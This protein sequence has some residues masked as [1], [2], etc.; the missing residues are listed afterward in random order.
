MALH[1]FDDI[2]DAVQATRSFLFPV[3][4]GTWLRLALVVFFTGG[5]S[6]NVPVGFDAPPSGVGAPAPSEVIPPRGDEIVLALVALVVLAV[7][8]ALVFGFVGSVFEFVFVESLRSEEVH[9]RRYWRRHWRRGARLFGFRLVLGLVGLALAGGLVALVALPALTG[10]GALSIGLLLALLPV[11]FVLALAFG[12]VNGFTTGFVVPAMLVEDRTVLGGWRRIWPVVR[13][14]WKEYAVYAVLSLLF[15]AALAMLVGIVVGVGAL[16]LAIPFVVLGV[17]VWAA[18]SFSTAGLVLLGALVVVYLVA[19]AVVVLFVQI[20]V[21][22]GLRYYA[23]L[24][25]GDTD[26]SI[27]PIPDQRAAVR[28]ETV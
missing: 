21:Q 19:L 2:D 3:D 24:L 5:V 16:L 10:S 7:A 27:D 1:A 11:A 17:A 26:P 9:V 15:R 13:A 4:R 23:L 18:L 28:D 22:T 25:L 12:L 8:V 14:E 6:A 20:P